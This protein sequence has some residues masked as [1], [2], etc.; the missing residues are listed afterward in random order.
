MLNRPDRDLLN[1]E[2]LRRKDLEQGAN[3]GE[4]LPQSGLLREQRF[5]LLTGVQHGRVIA[6]AEVFADRL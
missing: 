4:I 2:S 1:D 6:A 5:Q 3:F